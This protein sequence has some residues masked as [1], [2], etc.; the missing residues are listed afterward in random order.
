MTKKANVHSMGR[1]PES[2]MSPE[3]ERVRA[4]S[5]SLEGRRVG[6]LNRLPGERHIFAF[7]QDYVD[8][9]NRPTLSLSYKGH[10]GGLVT[11]VRPVGRR[12][13]PFFSNLLPEGQLREYIAAKAGV[14]KDR[15]FFLMAIVGEDLPGAVTVRP[16]D[17]EDA[18]DHEHHDDDDPQHP[19]QGMLRF[20]LAGVQLKFSAVL[21]AA[22]GLT[23]PAYGIGGAWIVKL[24]SMQY[25]AVPENEYVMLQLARAAGIEV[26]SIRLIRIGEI[27]GLPP[28]TARLQGNALAIERFDRAG[29][30]RRVHMED[31]AQVFGI[32]PDDK[33]SGRSYANIAAV[34][35]AETGSACTYEF[36]RRVV[37]SVLTGNADMHLKNWSL[38]YPDGRTPVLSP[39]YDF[40]A[41]V[42][43]IPGDTLA[44]SFGGSRSLDGITLEQ[45]RRFTDT[46]RLP[47]KP[48]WD[49]VLDMVERTRQAWKGL[50]EKELLPRDLLGTIDGQIEKVVSGTK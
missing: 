43:Y 45:V 30:G 35:W 2:G 44:L 37:F 48:V 1:M 8:A 18:D 34:L 16:L 49:I 6:I 23:I 7:E 17:A 40:V 22:G 15:E 41:T 14:K 50:P 46:A 4:L 24:P 42:P 21:N 5:V 36:V 25:P 11:A 27:T 38:L 12:L 29:D 31:F 10:M 32:F 3:L 39:A 9:P 26:P 13:S 19:Q 20:S 47:M 33:Y 28:D